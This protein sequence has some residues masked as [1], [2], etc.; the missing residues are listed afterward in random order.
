LND[1]NCGLRSELKYVVTAEQIPLLKSRINALLRPDSH[2]GAEGS[3]HISSVYFDDYQN[4]CFYE[5]E[6]GAASKEKFRIRIY[7][8]SAERIVLECKRKEYSKTNKQSCPI[9]MEQ[10]QMLLE[11]RMIADFDKLPRL[12]RKMVLQQRMR[13]LR[14]VVIVEYDRAAFVMKEGNV[15]V[16]FDMNI[17]A[18]TDITGFFTG[19]GAKRP[20]MPCGR[21]LME[22]KYDE[23]LPRSVH[24]C[25]NLGDIRQI[26]FSKY[27]LCRKLTI[28]K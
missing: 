25:L 11:G 20:V 9:T 23:Y 22:V 18:S 13:S 21:H 3:Y 19:T 12:L 8:H 27:H 4:R 7:D 2:T 6:N 10:A 5:N 24:G 16:T 26:T 15:R 28:C 17:A 14:P 1:T